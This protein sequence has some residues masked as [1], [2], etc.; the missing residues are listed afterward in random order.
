MDK[1]GQLGSMGAVGIIGGLIG[2]IIVI[3]I[4]AL[5][6]SVSNRIVNGFMSHYGR[7]IGVV[8]IAGIVSGIINWVLGKVLGFLPMLAM[9]GVGI[10]VAILIGGLIL[11]WLVRRPDGSPLG[12]PRAALAFLVYEIIVLIITAGLVMLVGGAM[13]A[14]MSG[15]AQ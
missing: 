14:G 4:A 9:R 15:M 1:L 10:I 2:L 13:M 12:Y 8:I 11:N 7:T 3:L 5:L 6:L